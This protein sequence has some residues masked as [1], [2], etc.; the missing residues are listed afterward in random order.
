MGWAVTVWAFSRAL[1]REVRA[2]EGVVIEVRSLATLDYLF[3]VYVH[4]SLIFSTWMIISINFVKD[5]TL[6]PSGGG[7]GPSIFS[8]IHLSHS[9]EWFLLSSHS[10]RLTSDTKLCWPQRLWRLISLHYI[11]CTKNP[12]QATTVDFIQGEKH[13]DYWY[14]LIMCTLFYY[15]MLI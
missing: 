1:S 14:T 6:Q 10:S 4:R 8:R 11:T 9:T 7:G 2:N 5:D 13:L 12:I 3:S 15:V